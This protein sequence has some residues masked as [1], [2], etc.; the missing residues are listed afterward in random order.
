MPEPPSRPDQGLPAPP[1]PVPGS[2]VRRGLDGRPLATWNPWQVIW[3]VLVGF[4]VGSLLAVPV[5]LL[6]GDTASKCSGAAG[7]SELL[8]GVVTDA[9][10]LVTLYIWLQ[11]RHK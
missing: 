7:P 3:I 10:V 9:G 1:P 11:R 6:M 2:T 5:F 8:Q 4:I